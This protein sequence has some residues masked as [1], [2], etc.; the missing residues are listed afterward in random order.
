VPGGD[1]RARGILHAGD[2]QADDLIN[3]IRRRREQA[4]EELRAAERTRADVE[5]LRR[6]AAR[7][8]RDA[9]PTRR[10]ARD[11]ATA[12]VEVELQEARELARQLQRTQHGVAAPTRDEARELSTKISTALDETGVPAASASRRRHRCS[13]HGQSGRATGPRPLA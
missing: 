2:Q 11:R 10:D 4:H 5:E 1:R 12:E 6:R 13:S 7:A 8:L 3:D 9:E